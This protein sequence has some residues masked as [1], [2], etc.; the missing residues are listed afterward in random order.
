MLK[1]AFFPFYA[2]ALESPIKKHGRVDIVE[3]SLCQ[4]K[5]NQTLEM[6][7]DICVSRFTLGFNFFLFYLCIYTLMK[8]E[9]L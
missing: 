7:L 2:R 1:H 3:Y 9:L 8:L 6:N 4:E 5:N